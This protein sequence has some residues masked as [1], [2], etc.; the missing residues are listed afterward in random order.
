MTCADFIKNLN[1]LN[2]GKDFPKDILKQLYHSIKSKP[3]VSPS[4]VEEE[5]DS[6]RE[7]LPV[8]PPVSV[9]STE[10]KRGYLMRKST[11]ESGGKKTP[12]GKRSWKMYFCRLRELLLVLSHDETAKPS[13]AIQNTQPIKV[14]HCYATVASDYHK[15]PHVFKLILAD[16]SQYLFQSSDSREMSSW[17]DILNW[18]AAKFSAPALEPPCSSSRRFERPLLPTSITRLTSRDQLASHQTTLAKFEEELNEWSQLLS[19]SKSGN[20][21]HKKEI[22][23]RLAF[24]QFE[25]RRYKSYVDELEKRMSEEAEN[26]GGSEELVELQVLPNP[27]SVLVEEADENNQS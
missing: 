25:I 2:D 19:G 6:N 13:G 24:Y 20:S 1:G 17:I 10:Y 4:E 22:K 21:N 8:E 26:N 12:F 18:N 9:S 11:F 14:H 7:V 27:P 16:R 15:R 23:E 3:L 5:E